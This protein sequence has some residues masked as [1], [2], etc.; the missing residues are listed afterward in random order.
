MHQLK[1]STFKHYHKKNRFLDQVGAL[2]KLK[3]NWGEVG[4]NILV[5]SIN[6][7]GPNY[8]GQQL[9]GVKINWGQTFWLVKQFGVKFWGVAKRNGVHAL[10]G[11]HDIHN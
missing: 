9:L 10:Y 8:L 2:K 7:W 5:G 1:F 4:V 6:F 3:T 11:I